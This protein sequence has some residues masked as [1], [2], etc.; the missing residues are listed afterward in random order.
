MTLSHCAVRIDRHS[1][2]LSLSVYVSH[3][4]FFTFSTI[5]IDTFIPFALFSLSIRELIFYDYFRAFFSVDSHFYTGYECVCVTS[6]FNIHAPSINKTAIAFI[7]HSAEHNSRIDEAMLFN[8]HIR[9]R[10]KYFLSRCKMKLEEKRS[11]KH[12]C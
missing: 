12:T 11:G 7:G 1:W 6:S 4:R 8:A 5:Y 9:K 3:S 2:E 10:S